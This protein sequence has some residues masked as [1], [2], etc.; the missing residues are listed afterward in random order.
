[1]AINDDCCRENLCLAV[2]TSISD[3][4]VARE[5]D[6]LV[7]LHGKPACIVNDN[8]LVGKQWRDL[9]SRSLRADSDWRGI[10]SEPDGFDRQRDRSLP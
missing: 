5:L 8:V 9:A 3:A 10:H 4:R 1:L 6:A 7:R 2:D